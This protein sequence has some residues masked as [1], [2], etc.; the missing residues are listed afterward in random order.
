ML[1]F[2]RIY[3][4]EH[5][6]PRP[7]INVRIRVILTNVNTLTSPRMLPAALLRRP[8][9]RLKPSN[10]R[11]YTIS[12]HHLNMASAAAS[13][14]ATNGLSPK[15]T[16]YTN[17]SCPFA[18]RAHTTLKEL[19][20]PYE[21]VIIDLDRPRDESYLK[22]NPVSSPPAQKLIPSETLNVLFPT[23]WTRPLHLLLER[24]AR[25]RNRH[26]VRHRRAVPR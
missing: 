23:A 18:H 6:G 12:P 20:L 21:E 11:S 22:I 7:N 9:F 26:R 17:H 4:V 10:S 15:I 16:L 14:P 1:Q 24:R 13:T 2:V 25:R 5:F 3:A 19:N 8:I